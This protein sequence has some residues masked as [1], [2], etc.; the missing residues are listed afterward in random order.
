MKAVIID[1][2]SKARNLLDSLL[3]EYCPEVTVVGSA[4][5]LP[6]GVDLIRSTQPNIVFLDVE[7]PTYSGLQILDF[8]SPGEIQFQIIF[9]TAY[10][11]YAIKAFELNAIAYLL[12]PLRPGQLKE[13]VL[14]A[15]KQIS[16]ESISE[17]LESLKQGLSTNKFGKIALPVTDGILFVK[18]SNIISLRA[19]GM[20][21]E[22]NTTNGKIVVSKPLKT[23]EKL[24]DKELFLRTH[25]SYIANIS[26]I[27]QLVRR[28]GKYLLMDDDSVVSLS[29]ERMD[30]LL[31]LLDID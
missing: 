30:Q 15:E 1:D 10:D 22:F 19:D 7:M 26:F 25:R 20:Y 18:Q 31:E 13:A 21:T 29:A 3:S 27:K 11:E 4:P 8:F 9:T 12:K 24:L 28:N 16:Q 14:K 2:E 23:F 5:D 6:S 17:Q